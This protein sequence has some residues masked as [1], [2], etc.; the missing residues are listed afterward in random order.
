MICSSILEYIGNTP[1]VEFNRLKKQQQGQLLVK[2]ECMNPG[3]SHKTR[4]AYNMIKAAEQKGL[5]KRGS[6]QTIL[7]PTG[8]NLGKGIATVASVLGYKV[9]LVIPDNYSET[10][11]NYL[12]TFGCEIINSNS[13]LGTD[14]HFKLAQKLLAE[15]PDYVMLNQTVNP[16]NPEVH[17]QATAEEI[18]KDIKDISIDYFVAGIGTGGHITGIGKLLKKYR[19]EI[20]IIGVQPEGCEI[21]DGKFAKHQIQGIGVGKHPVLNPQVV[22]K[23]I[24]VDY[25]AVKEMMMRAAREEG[26]SVGISSA[27]NLVAA[28]NLSK[29]GKK[30]NVL[31]MIYDSGID[32]LDTFEGEHS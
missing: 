12:R 27:A 14:S 16:A 13:K 22:D 19:P 17:Y 9:I 6:G 24:S 8:G 26:I 32:Y 20:K 21:L 28:L 25:S 31:T 15:N 23:M 3:G 4:T 29:Q 30:V 11:K 10:K 18:L 2:L 1:V 7:E 5:L